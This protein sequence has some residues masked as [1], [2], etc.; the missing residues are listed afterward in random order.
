[1]F[2]EGSL[3]CDVYANNKELDKIEAIIIDIKKEKN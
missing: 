1:M 2:H 3:V